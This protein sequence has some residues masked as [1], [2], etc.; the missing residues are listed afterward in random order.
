ARIACG[1]TRNA[2]GDLLTVRLDE[3][4]LRDLERRV[5]EI[6]VCEGGNDGRARTYGRPTVDGGVVRELRD[7]DRIAE[8]IV[9]RSRVLA[10]CQRAKP[11]LRD[12]RVLFL[13]ALLPA[14]VGR[15]AARLGLIEPVAGRGDGAE[16]R[17]GRE[18]RG[19]HEEPFRNACSIRD[20]H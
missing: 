5:F 20:A 12:G 7:D 13:R 18:C 6:L 2:S 9:N 1:S 19:T 3:D 17:G 16:E 8:E 15:F 11:A 14:L 4:L 10:F